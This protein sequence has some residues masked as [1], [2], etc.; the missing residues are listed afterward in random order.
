MAQRRE[1]QAGQQSPITMRSLCE[2][3]VRLPMQYGPI[4]EWTLLRM[5]FPV[6]LLRKIRGNLQKP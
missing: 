2:R 4:G 6:K 5:W 1:K 3:F